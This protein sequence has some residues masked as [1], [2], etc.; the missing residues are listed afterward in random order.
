MKSQYVQSSPALSF[1]V[2]KQIFISVDLVSSGW[3]RDWN[4]S[5]VTK[6]KRI[7]KD[8]EIRGGSWSFYTVDVNICLNSSSSRVGGGDTQGQLGKKLALRLS[9]AELSVLV[10]TLSDI[11]RATQISRF[12]ASSF[13]ISYKLSLCWLC[14]V[15]DHNITNAACL[16]AMIRI[17]VKIMKYIWVKTNM[18]LSN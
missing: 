14:W 7:V 6:I 13:R 8:V 17:C 2:N 4:V 9:W 11:K 15:V 3:V 5:C 16:P 10:I 12:K 1:H 18:L